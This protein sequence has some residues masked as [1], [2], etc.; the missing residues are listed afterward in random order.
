MVPLR[1]KPPSQGQC[2]EVWSIGRLLQGSVRLPSTRFS[3]ERHGCCLHGDSMVCCGSLSPTHSLLTAFKECRRVHE[4]RELL[5]R[6]PP[7]GR[8]QRS[9]CCGQGAF[10]VPD[11]VRA[12]GGVAILCWHGSAKAK[13][14]LP[15]Q[16]VLGAH[17]LRVFFAMRFL[18]TAVVGM[19]SAGPLHCALPQCSPPCNRFEWL[20]LRL[21]S[22]R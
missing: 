15:L 13:A 4:V 22:H 17:P 19:T 14:A 1:Q 18:W 6:G 5:P 20:A 3:T 9:Q 16:F 10:H 21:H 2:T 11:I 7:V 12:G 8:L